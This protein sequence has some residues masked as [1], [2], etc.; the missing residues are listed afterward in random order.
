MDYSC[1]NLSSYRYNNTPLCASKSVL[2]LPVMPHFEKYSFLNQCSLLPQKLPE[3]KF[4]QPPQFL[5]GGFVGSKV[6]E[7][8]NSPVKPVNPSNLLGQI[9]SVLNN[10][11]ASRYSHSTQ[12]PQ[13]KNSAAPP[14]APSPPDIMPNG[15]MNKKDQRTESESSDTSWASVDTTENNNKMLT[16]PWLS[17]MFVCVNDLDD[18]DSSSDWDCVDDY[19]SENGEVVD[20]VRWQE[21]GV[22]LSPIRSPVNPQRSEAAVY[23]SDDSDESDG[24]LISCGSYHY[25]EEEERRFAEERFQ[26]LESVNQKWNENMD[27]GDVT[28]SSLKKVKSK[29]VCFFKKS[30]KKRLV[31]E[32][33]D[34]SH[35]K[36]DLLDDFL[37]EFH[38][39]REIFS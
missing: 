38:W 34:G 4:F 29:Q 20:S 33:C 8:K 35:F 17:D 23:D 31:V 36:D 28:D 26:F 9:F 32:Y 6:C 1:L 11:T 22:P 27:T 10:S 2:K 13:R 3:H 25:D 21:D 5:V 18:S 19:Q 16:S 14:I 15:A 39:S 12:V 30:K 7:L 37:L 24:I